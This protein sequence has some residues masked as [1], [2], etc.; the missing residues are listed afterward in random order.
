MKEAGG[1]EDAESLETE[2]AKIQPALVTN[3]VMDQKDRNASRIIQLVA[4]KY[5]T[6]QPTILGSVAYDRQIHTMVT[7]MV[8]LTDV[9]RTSEAFANLYDITTKLI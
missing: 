1:K 5:L 8:P 3:M 7:N 4:E 6:I 9:D 2:I